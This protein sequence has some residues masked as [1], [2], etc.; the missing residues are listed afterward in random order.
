[1]KVEE[2]EPSAW[3]DRLGQ[4]WD[5]LFDQSPHS[6]IFLSFP[7]IQ[8]W[9]RHFGRDAA[10]R[11]MA[12]WGDDGALWALAP[13]DSRRLSIAGVPALGI[14]ALMGDQ[15]AG[16]EYLGILLRESVE[17]PSLQA[18]AG[19]LGNGWPLLDLRG[20]REDRPAT[21]LFLQALA[22]GT[23]KRVHREK[24]PCSMIPL[25]RDYEVY[26]ASLPQKFRSTLRYRTNKLT[27]S[28][29]VRMLRTSEAVELDRHLDRF[30]SM[31]QARWTSE[32][33]PG[34]FYS[35]AKRAFYGE[36]SREFL[37]RGWLRFYQLE[38]DGIIRASQFGFVHRGVLHSLQEAFD[39]DFRPPGVGGV[40]VVLRGMAIQ[41]C[42]AEG[43]HGYD[44]L[45][46]VEDFK[47]RWGTRTHYVDRVRIGAAGLRGGLAFAA[48]AGV[49]QLKDW[50]RSR[51]P[52][53]LLE[54][55]HRFQIW[56]RTRKVRPPAAPA[57]ED[58]RA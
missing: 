49:R 12:I 57:T 35:P 28:F 37:K 50:G 51:A 16:S 34:S 26:L 24:H 9:W 6:T 13:L 17:S 29:T 39:H 5:E 23:G 4:A 56:R 1:V 31:H 38:V 22:A 3:P 14:L 33:H 21:E 2:I 36:V 52:A 11:M 32:G 19:H 30:F 41:D 48:T 55:R 53:W 58:R 8:S 25:P 44:F 40:G 42:I 47:V 45:G 54:G 10:P 7:W 43:M 20:L 15:G 27:K 46:G 18:L